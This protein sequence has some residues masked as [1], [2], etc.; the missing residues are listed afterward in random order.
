MH[1]SASHMDNH[2][3]ASRL[4]NQQQGEGIIVIMG[5]GMGMGMGMH[6]D[7]P[8][9]VGVHSMIMIDEVEVMVSQKCLS[10]LQ[11][12]ALPL[13]YKCTRSTQRESNT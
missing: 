10:I 7:L 6:P 9:G 2:N 8:R 4:V 3:I 5:M 11:S 1:A 12:N 13:S